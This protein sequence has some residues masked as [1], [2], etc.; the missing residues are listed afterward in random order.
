MIIEQFNEKDITND[1]L[2][3]IKHK[4]IIVPK[5]DTEFLNPVLREQEWIFAHN[6]IRLLMHR[7]DIDMDIARE[8]RRAALLDD[9]KSGYI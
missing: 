6:F 2:Y 3:T 4:Q 7:L 5:R 9:D 1:L 8:K